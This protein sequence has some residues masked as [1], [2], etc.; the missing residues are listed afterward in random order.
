MKNDMMIGRKF[1]RL[2]V[3]EFVGTDKKYHKRYRCICECGKI[4]VTLGYCLR[5]GHTKSCGCLHREK[6]RANA[7]RHGHHSRKGMSPTYCSWYSM[8]TRCLNP[9]HKAYKYYGACGITVCE[10]WRKFENFLADMGVRPDGTSIDRIDNNKGY[11]PGNCRWATPKEQANNRK[12]RS[13]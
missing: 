3:I 8:K 7:T 11:S 6:V 2:I 5:N 10:R 9:N 1:G 4:H 13:A 12:Q